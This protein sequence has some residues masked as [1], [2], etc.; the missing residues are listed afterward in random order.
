MENPNWAP[1]TISSLGSK[2]WC[3]SGVPRNGGDIQGWVKHQTRWAE[4]EKIEETNK[5]TNKQWV[6]WGVQGYWRRVLDSVCG[7]EH[8]SF[9]VEGQKSNKESQ[10]GA[11][12]V[13]LRKM[14][15][16]VIWNKLELPSCHPR[17][18]ACQRGILPSSIKSPGEM[19][20]QRQDGLITS[21]CW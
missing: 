1:Q 14:L 2:C 8:T 5:Q 9:L 17:C 19:H 15:L 12:T 21:Q 18:T 10:G 6:M 11:A 4:C 3:V 13:R 20:T 16:D 7:K